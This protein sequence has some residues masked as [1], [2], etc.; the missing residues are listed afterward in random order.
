LPT[1]KYEPYETEINIGWCLSKPH[2]ELPV[3]WQLKEIEAAFTAFKIH[4]GITTQ[5]LGLSE[6]SGPRTIEI[7]LTQEHVA[8]QYI[9]LMLWKDPWNIDTHGAAIYI[10]DEALFRQM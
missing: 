3:D 1:F 8:D 4:I 7:Q 2:K 10:N 6:C 5:F 9:G